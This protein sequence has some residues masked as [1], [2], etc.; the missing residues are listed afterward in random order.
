[1]HRYYLELSVRAR[2]QKFV[3]HGLFVAIGKRICKF[4]TKTRANELITSIK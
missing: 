2:I 1:M 3:E 4:L